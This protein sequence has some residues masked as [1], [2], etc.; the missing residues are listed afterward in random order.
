M[1]SFHLARMLQL[2][3]PV[4]TYVRREYVLVQHV[5]VQG[6]STDVPQVQIDILVAADRDVLQEEVNARGGHVLP[7]EIVVAELLDDAGLKKYLCQLSSI[8]C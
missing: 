4:D 7:S 2:Q 1:I 3:S 8:H 5:A 6:E